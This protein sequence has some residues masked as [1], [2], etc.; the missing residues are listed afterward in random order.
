M[1]GSTDLARFLKE[2]TIFAD[3]SAEARRYTA[4]LFTERRMEQDEVL[5]QQ[6][7]PGDALYIV[8]SGT[9]GVIV[10]TDSGQ[11]LTVA[12]LEAGDFL[13][14]MSIFE[15][16]PRSATCRALEDTVVLGLREADFNRLVR[17]HPKAA[18]SIMRSILETVAVRLDNTSVLVSDMVQWGETARRRAFTDELTGLYNRRFLDETMS[19][20]INEAGLSGSPLCVVMM[21]L[22]RFS[23]INAE[24]GPEV[25][26][27]L[28]A[29]VAPVVAETFR[30]SDILARYGGDE[31]TFLLPGTTPDEAMELCAELRTA[32]SGMDFL[33][34]QGGAVT[35]VSA[36]QGIALWPDHGS[37]GEELL[38]AADRALYQAKQNGRNRSEIAG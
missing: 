38:A 33:A 6:G 16:E 1:N 13:G 12:A 19:E 35:S 29:A 34:Q 18:I 32:L 14:E 2:V 15:Q 27:Q 7:D 3:V 24:Y 23:A 30:E 10:T 28:I 37:T 25:G 11:E 36:S 4:E 8:R 20:Q 21:D 31:F 26:D 17:T 22:D 9:V 5:F